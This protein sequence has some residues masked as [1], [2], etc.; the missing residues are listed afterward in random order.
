MKAI[1]Q[2]QGWQAD[3]YFFGYR[4]HYLPEQFSYYDI[5]DHY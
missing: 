5:A 4:E 3:F 1:S 2:I